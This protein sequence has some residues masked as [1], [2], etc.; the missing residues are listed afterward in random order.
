MM[1]LGTAGIGEV[2]LTGADI[3]AVAW[4]STAAIIVP[5]VLILLGLAIF[6][7]TSR[8]RVKTIGQIAGV[9][10]GLVLFK[11]LFDWLGK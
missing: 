7:W 5:G 10:S 2:E 4:F 11:S 9:L 3:E 6:G 8:S 1:L